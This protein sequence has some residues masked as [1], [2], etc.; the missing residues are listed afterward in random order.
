MS[1]TLPP[2]ESNDGILL[3]WGYEYFPATQILPCF[4]LK[5]TLQLLKSHFL[6][7]LRQ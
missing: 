2:V 3:T 7:P 5:H 1:P 6:L 4:A